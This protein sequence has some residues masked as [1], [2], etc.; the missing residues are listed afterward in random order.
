MY[1]TISIIALL[2]L[3]V[4]VLLRQARFGKRPAG[5]RLEKIKNSPNYKN[6]S[7]QNE[8]I[9]PDLTEGAS[10]F[11]VAKEFFFG[12]RKRVTPTNTI[13]SIKT[14]LL[15][16]DIDKNILVWFGHSSYFMQID[17]KR[18]LVDPVL[19]GFASPFS[20]ST[21]AFKG[22]DI[23]TTDDL[24]EI[25]YL[26]IS[27]DHW[28][29]F[30]YETVTQLKPK[31]KKVICGLGTGEHLEHWGYNEDQIIEK[32]WNEQIILEDGFIVD[33][34]PGRHFS[35]RGLKRNQ[36]LWTAFVL[37]TPTMKIFMG[38]DSGYDK[39]FT[40][41]GK[42]FGP[43]DLA[44]LENGQYDKSWKYIHMMPGEVLQAAKDLHAKRLLPVHSSKF[45]IANHAWDE[46][47]AKITE[48]NKSVN[49][50][51]ITPLIGEAVDLKDEA[52]QF[53]EWWKNID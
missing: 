49:I 42:S 6:G 34:V 19:C 37:Q 2:S 31:V 12:K 36:A 24:P 5:K 16:L 14:D 27:H 30:D 40:A 50:P 32:D 8:S 17:G 23:Y 4:I 52:Q 46:P 9:T 20:F 13:P 3:A 44:I 53:T 18:I 41:I 22:T 35:G 47:L 29:H 39:H 48:L 7:F 43:F 33:T 25:D 28:D 38:G 11:S 1:I 51:V 45:A 15:H 21:K 10:Y 26:F